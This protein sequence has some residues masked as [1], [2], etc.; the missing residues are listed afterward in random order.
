MQH[1]TNDSHYDLAHRQ[2]KKKERK[3]KKKEKKVIFAAKVW[4]FA[5]KHKFVS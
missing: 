2:K 5:G 4:T 1:F 3:R